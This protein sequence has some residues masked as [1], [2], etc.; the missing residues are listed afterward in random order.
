[1]IEQYAQVLAVEH[2]SV[3]IVTQRQSG[4]QSCDVKG[5]CGTSLI[6]RLFPQRPQQQLR[7]PLG[8]LSSP[9][10]PGDRVIIGIDET[11]LHSSTLS[12]YVIPLIGLLG[13]AVAGSL[14]GEMPGSP[15][16]G[17]PMSIL[18]CLLGL[19][20]GL[21]YARS[22]S[23]EWVRKP[24][25]VIKLLRVESPPFSVPVT[26]DILSPGNQDK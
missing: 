18:L 10:T 5:G 4:C 8:D 1:M 15:L 9:P 23:A 24:G 6:G 17:E 19:I 16:P 13:G 26:T 20:L 7:L 14:L 25:H 3:L 21:A 22:R 2:D 11:H 12:L